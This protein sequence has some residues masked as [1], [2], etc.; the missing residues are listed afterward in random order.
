MD[1]SNI[2]TAIFGGGCFW[3]V[4]AIF[5]RL[6][7]V[8]SVVSGYAGGL[9]EN[10]TYE[11]V[12]SGIT[13]HA[14]VIKIEFDPS[15]IKFEILLDV[16]F[17]SHDPTTL[18]KQGADSGTQYRSVIYYVNAEQ[19]KSIDEYIQKLKID[20]IFENEI[21]TEVAAAESFYA[22]EEYHQ[23]F[24]DQNREYPYCAFVIDPKI[25]KLR[26]KYSEF[27]KEED[28]LINA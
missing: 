28:D 27:L 16:F 11:Q 6:K 3:C 21:V 24:Y 18:D 13:G 10:P 15:I 20:K 12:S 5:K 2:Q 19:K 26:A 23:N 4:E 22:A 14:E 8:H 9:L 7:G 25:N 17:S 1:M